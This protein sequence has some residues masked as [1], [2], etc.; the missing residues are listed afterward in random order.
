LFDILRKIPGIE[1][2]KS[3]GGRLISYFKRKKVGRPTIE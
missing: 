2:K 1:K 3:G